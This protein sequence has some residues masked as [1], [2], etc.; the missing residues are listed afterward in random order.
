MSLSF[1][2]AGMEVRATLRLLNGPLCGCEYRLIDKTTLVVAGSAASF[3]AGGDAEEVPEFP[4]NAIVIPIDGGVNFE[5]IVDDNARDGFVLR[6]LHPS[7]EEQKC[8]YQNVCQIGPLSFTLRADGADWDSSVVECAPLPVHNLS[9]A[10]RSKI[11]QALFVVS[12][13][14]VLVMLGAV[15][16][17]AFGENKKVAEI[18]AV[19]AGSSESYRLV[20]GSDGRV[21]IFA[22]TERDVA[23][24][25][26]ALMREG[27]AKSAYVS[28]LRNEEAR[29][30]RLLVETYPSLAFYRI[31]L[32]DPLKP[33]LLLSQERSLLDVKQRKAVMASMTAWMPYAESVATAI[34]ADAMVDGRAKAELEKM[35]V[36]FERSESERGISYLIQGDLSDVELIK[37]QDFI[38]RFYSDFG[39]RYIQFSVV[40]KEDWLKGKSFKYGGSGFVKMNPQHWFFPLK[41]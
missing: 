31:R 10:R 40:L 23:W 29:V 30:R 4:E 35:A 36:A 9:H 39:S 26:Q 7:V 5:I 28:T 14:F 21:Y 33:E 18:A 19:V 24:A 20:R 37:L 17:E 15:L 22:A 12:F 8:E 41:F 1:E 34:W 2:E 6:T 27:L 25:K 3:L 11:I 38:N 16:W 13:L 32:L